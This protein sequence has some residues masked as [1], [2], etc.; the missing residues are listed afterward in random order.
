MTFF[1][2][3]LKNISVYHRKMIEKNAGLHSPTKNRAEPGW[4]ILC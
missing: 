3:Y 4:A 2:G 1:F